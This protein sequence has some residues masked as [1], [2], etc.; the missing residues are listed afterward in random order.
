M[1]ENEPTTVLVVGAGRS[2]AKVLKQLQKNPAL[3][4]LTL[5]ARP[6]PHAVQLGIIDSVD[7]IEALTPLSLDYI[8]Q[9][10]EPDLILLT[11]TTED[12]GLG[13]APGLDV[14]A[15]ALRQELASVASVP[16]IMVARAGN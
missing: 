13:S 12:L 3:R 5:D 6:D 8:L 16:V 11:T 10:A 9:V 4:V 2:G 1:A 7:F 14:L 15:D